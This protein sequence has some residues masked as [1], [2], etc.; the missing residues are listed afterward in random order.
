MEVQVSLLH[1]MAPPFRN[2]GKSPG[3]LPGTFFKGKFWV[4]GK[5]FLG[6]E[7]HQ[8]FSKMIKDPIVE[9]EPEVTVTGGAVSHISAGSKQRGGAETYEDNL[10]VSKQTGNK[11]TYFAKLLIKI[12]HIC[13][14][15]A[16]MTINHN[17]VI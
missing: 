11:Y 10:T 2:Q 14:Q 6:K 13:E 15:Y 16:A 5:F 4:E 1:Q 7:M 12:P 17:S 9:K 3:F 8:G